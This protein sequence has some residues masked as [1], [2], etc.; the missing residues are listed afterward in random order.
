[1]HR[2]TSELYGSNEISTIEDYKELNPDGEFEIRYD[3]NIYEN[4]DDEWVQVAER[5][6]EVETEVEEFVTVDGIVLKVSYDGDVWVDGG[7]HDDF[8]LKTLDIGDE[9]SITFELT[10]DELE[11]ARDAWETLNEDQ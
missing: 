2:N 11:K 9:N 4:V 10:N 6:Y 8:Y 1:M 5:V 7:K 3:G